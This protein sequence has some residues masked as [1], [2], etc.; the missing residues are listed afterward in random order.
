MNFPSKASN[1]NV[2]NEIL[3]QTVVHKVKRHFNKV[4]FY[5]EIQSENSIPLKKEI[6]AR[7]DEEEILW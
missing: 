2:I 4:T 3:L 5:I 6:K 7:K 1:W